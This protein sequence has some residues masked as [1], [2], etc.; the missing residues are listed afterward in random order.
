MKLRVL[1][2]A[3]LLFAGL[4]ANN[5]RPRVGQQRSYSLNQKKTP[6][7]PTPIEEGVMTETQRLHS[8]L[9]GEYKQTVTR[10]KSLHTL[11]L[12]KGDD[13]QVSQGIGDVILPQSFTLEQYL[14]TMSCQADAIV[15]GSVDDKYSNLIEDGSFTFTEYHVVAQDVLKE[16]AATYI[17][18]NTRI[19]VVRVGGAVRLLHHNVRAIDYAQKPLAIGDRYLFF[20]KFI[21]STG[22]YRSFGDPRSDDTFRIDD[23]RIAQVSE[24]VLPL[25]A[26][27]QTDTD[28]FL[29]EV[30]TASS[31]SC[32]K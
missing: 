19:T 3:I 17:P 7:L 5:L 31:K 32:K 18:V 8:R 26:N 14:A 11:V 29:K 23:D 16:N 22:A 6:E 27:R 20:L 12:E 24:Q 21:S 9:F 25:G 1:P 13:V 15:I 30:R 4:A 10:G 28:T 2:I